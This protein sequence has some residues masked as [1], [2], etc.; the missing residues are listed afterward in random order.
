MK[1]VSQVLERMCVASRE[2]FGRNTMKYESCGEG[3]FTY[4]NKCKDAVNVSFAEVLH[5]G[6]L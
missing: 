3:V 1:C 2:V 6:I 4:Q 5:F